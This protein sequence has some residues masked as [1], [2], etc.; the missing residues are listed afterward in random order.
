MTPKDFQALALKNPGA[1]ES[2]HVGHPDFRYNGKVFATLGYPAEGWAMVKLTPEQQRH[3]LGLSPGVF[4]AASGAWG[5]AGSTTIQLELA[6]KTVVKAA[7]T[8]AFTN[9][10]ALNKASLMPRKATKRRP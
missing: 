2:E 1:F 6:K 10:A 5:K 3:Y 9:I 4:H 8:A 7:L